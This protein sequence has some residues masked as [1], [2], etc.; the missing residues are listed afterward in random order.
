M[1]LQ[2]DV[3]N[4][5][6]PMDTRV[7]LGE[8]GYIRLSVGRN[9]PLP[10]LIIAGDLCP[11]GQ[12]ERLL[13]NSQAGRLFDGITPLLQ[14]A[15]LSIVN[16]ECP[17]TRQ[18]KPIIKSGPHL[19]ADPAC[20]K[21]IRSAGFDIVSLS[22][23]HILDMGAAGLKDTLIACTGAGL[24]TVGAGVNLVDAT[25]P[26]VVDIQG[27]RVAI[28]AFTENEFSIATSCSAGA[29]PVD[30]IDNTFQIRQV[31]PNAD[32]VLVLLH[33]GNEHYAL[34]NPGMVK[35]CRYLVDLGAD[36]VVCNHVHAPS[37]IEIY[38]RAPIIYS[39][40]NLLFEWENQP[41]QWYK[42]YLTK[43]FIQPGAVAAVKLIPYWQSKDQP[44]VA[45]M[46][47]SE[48]REFFAHLS[49]LAAV[50]ADPAAL[51][52]EWDLFVRS[53]RI[54][55]LSL[56]LGLNR[57]ERQMLRL[58]IGPFGRLGRSDGPGLLNLFTCESHRDLMISLLS[59]EFLPQEHRSDGQL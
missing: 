48:Q 22:N 38:E 37:G 49:E 26:L 5:Q 1:T 18:T 50:I 14:T 20:A 24:R 30:P 32:F 31:A 2:T 27:T 35:L 25:Q 55:Y 42:G 57:A 10:S 45:L 40:G 21:G 53:K 43:L 4:R 51:R 11:M 44:G 56:I 8:D 58:G 47:H 9:E 15:D 3:W 54:Q 23:N 41:A 36:A 52:K 16:L 59:S 13:G 19:R 33:G 46:N 17:L 29:W 39:T 28:L 7:T 6:A 34:P 12:S